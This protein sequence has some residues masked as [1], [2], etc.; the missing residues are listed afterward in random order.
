MFG[1]FLGDFLGLDGAE[2]EEVVVWVCG[3]SLGILFGVLMHD[4]DELDY[5]AALVDLI[6]FVF[7][8]LDAGEVVLELVGVGMRLVLG[9]QEV[10]ILLMRW[11]VVEPALGLL[12]DV[13]VVIALVLALQVFSHI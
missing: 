1:G 13:G 8:F 3:C 11:L 9:V 10:L 4:V 7:D 12:E 6:I 2:A 5:P